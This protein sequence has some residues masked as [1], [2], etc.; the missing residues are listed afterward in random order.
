MEVVIAYNEHGPDGP[1]GEDIKV[2]YSAIVMGLPSAEALLQL[3]YS[4]KKSTHTMMR[5]FFDVP[6]GCR[7]V[8]LDRD[9]RVNGRGGFS[10]GWNGVPDST[11]VLVGELVGKTLSYCYVTVHGDSAATLNNKTAKLAEATQGMATEVAPAVEQKMHETLS[12]NV[13]KEFST[14]ANTAVLISSFDANAHLTR[15]TQVE[16]ERARELMET[17]KASGLNDHLLEEEAKRLARK[18]K[19]E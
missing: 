9:L 15:Q 4:E 2:K 14:N 8:A 13:V 5:R 6:E 11:L 1:M 18:A 10:Y 17:M 19:R 16:R 3:L 7:T 12:A